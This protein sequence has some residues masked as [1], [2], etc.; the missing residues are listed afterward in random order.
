M[1]KVSKVQIKEFVKRKLSTDPVWARHAL[2]KIFEFQTI[3][4]QK[5]KDTMFNNGVGFTGTDGRILS[6]LATQL[7]RKRYLSEKQMTLLLKKMPKYWIQV[8]KMSDKEMLNSLIQ[9]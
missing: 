5:S 4:E 1:N 7:L 2:L 8:V 3:E 6:S 9:S